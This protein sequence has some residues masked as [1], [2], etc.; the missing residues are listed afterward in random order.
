MVLEEDTQLYIIEFKYCKSSKEALSQIKD[1][2]YVRKY[3]NRI[4]RKA[5]HLLGINFSA[6]ERNID[7][8]SEEIIS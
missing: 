8:W 3:M 6:E 5:I 1:N 2:D 4:G 7:S